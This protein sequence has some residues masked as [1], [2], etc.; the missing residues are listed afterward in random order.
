MEKEGHTEKPHEPA[1]SQLG[2]FNFA[3]PGKNETV[4]HDNQTDTDEDESPADEI[5]RLIE[6][7]KR[8]IKRAFACF[9]RH[10]SVV[11]AVATIVI[12]ISTVLYAVLTGVY[13]HYS[14]A[15]WD[16]M[17]ISAG[18]AR[19]AANTA[20]AQLEV[21]ERPWISVSFA[22]VS[23]LVIDESGLR[24]DIQTTID[25]EGHSPAV[26]GAQSLKLY[27]GFL[28]TP[29]PWKAREETCQEAEKI[30]NAPLSNTHNTLTQTW[31]I[32]RQPPEVISYSI[33]RSEITRGMVRLDQVP[34]GAT[35][36]PWYAIDIAY[37][38]AYASP[39][40]SKQYHTGYS[41]QIVRK[42]ALPPPKLASNF[43]LER[44]TVPVRVIY[45]TF[46]GLIPMGPDAN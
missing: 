11:T 7:V 25:N 1:D 19:D 26:K 4:A 37:C 8:P 15:Q 39:F 5:V 40:G 3:Y 20:A 31:F 22:A 46:S 23:P 32:G 35:P 36:P 28:L 13:V 34:R 45:G 2:K 6:A 16:Q 30:S 14:S 38:V 10:N 43:S 41:L 12:A 24:V 42:I 21:A 17:K 33:S 27:T 44:E 29:D 9:F 18:A